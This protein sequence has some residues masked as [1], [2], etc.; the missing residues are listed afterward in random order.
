MNVRL[1]VSLAGLLLMCGVAK[2]QSTRQES[3][4]VCTSIP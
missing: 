3:A 1:F 2:G 4:S